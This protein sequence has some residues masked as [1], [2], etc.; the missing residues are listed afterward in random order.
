MF[1]SRKL[2]F[3][4]FFLIMSSFSLHGLQAK[5]PKQ[6]DKDFEE[7]IVAPKECLRLST[8]VSSSTQPMRLQFVN[9]CQEDIYAKV[10]ILEQNGKAN[11][12]ESPVRIPRFGT[13][14]LNLFP[15]EDPN[16]VT[17]ASAIGNPPTPAPCNKNTKQ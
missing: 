14:N 1:Y 7:I 16:K 6:K 17:W 15:G 11:L 2:L 3:F 10:C 12:H 4:A 9:M 13:F 8:P 5:Q